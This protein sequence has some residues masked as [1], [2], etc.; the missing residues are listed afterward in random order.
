VGPTALA[1][2]TSIGM[3]GHM[4]GAAHKRSE[5][6]PFKRGNVIECSEFAGAK[7]PLPVE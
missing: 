7:A 1:D 4:A 2:I 6:R 3:F 5:N